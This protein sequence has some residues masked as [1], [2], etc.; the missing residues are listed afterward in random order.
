MRNHLI[1]ILTFSLAA[2]GWVEEYRT[3]TEYPGISD[4]SKVTSFKWTPEYFQVTLISRH[5]GTRDHVEYEWN[6]GEPYGHYKLPPG[7]YKI[8]YTGIPWYS[9][10]LFNGELSANFIAGHSYRMRS[11]VDRPGF[12]NKPYKVY[13]WIDDVT[14]GVK[15]TD[16]VIHCY[17]SI[18]SGKQ[19]AVCP[20]VYGDNHR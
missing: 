2:C 1:L 20:G 11:S 7:H 4:N 19:P 8:S 6:D 10:E 13:V 18:S 15:V 16:T 3:P 12:G 17:V 14:Q 5:D 9:R